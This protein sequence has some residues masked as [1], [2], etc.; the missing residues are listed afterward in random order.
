M[1]PKESEFF[2]GEVRTPA[3]QAPLLLNLKLL[4][5]KTIV[6]RSTGTVICWTTDGGIPIFQV[7]NLR[8]IILS[9]YPDFYA[10]QKNPTHVLYPNLLCK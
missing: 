9:F 10:Y 5:P 3:G 6:V 1:T 2:F 8:W 4:T 7:A